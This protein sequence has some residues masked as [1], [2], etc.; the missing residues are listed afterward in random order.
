MT[1]C[2]LLPTRGRVSNL[3][4]FLSSAREMGCSTPGMVILDSDDFADNEFAY[5]QAMA[6]AP[7]GWVVRII[8]NP[9]RCYGGALRTVWDGVKDMDWIGLV[10]DDLVACS[11]NW[12]VSLV[13]ALNRWNFVSSNDGWQSQTGDIARDR[14]HGAIVWAGELARAVGWIF[15][16][17]LNHI[18]HDDVWE[19]IGRET[20]CWQVRKDI[21]VK[22]LHEAL[23]GKVG[24]TMDQSSDLWKHDQAWYQNW[25]KTEK[26][27]VVSRVRAL[28][29]QCG[30]RTMRAD[31]TGVKLMIGTP[32]IDGKYESAYMTSLFQT[33]Q[34]L[35]DNGVTVMVAEEKFTADISLARSKIFG[36]FLRSDC[37]HLLT[38]DSD[39]GWQPEAISR[40]F[41]ANKDFAAAAG[42]KKRYPLQF[43]ASYTDAQGNPIMLQLDAETGTM[44]VGEI[45]SAFAMI[46]H[47]VADKMVQSYPEL[48]YIGVSGETEFA[49]YNPMV[50]NA[51]YRSED[52]AFCTRWRNIGGH[53]YM[54]P[55]IRLQHIGSHTFEGS[56]AEVAYNP[57]QQ[58]AE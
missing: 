24:P 28:Q 53:V 42:P 34:M 49:I 14:M 44:E 8:E 51:R 39:M 37:T 18:F 31:F 56:F 22:H 15:P 5:K 27:E 19:I 13:R 9:D 41:V 11:S 55:E 26:D 12:D 30:I 3:R 20:G 54:I 21:L 25:L 29:G 40:L 10:S 7:P 38:I 58:A 46:T 2:W 33:L 50:T 43:A 17:G 6:L 47:A 16:D 4:R 57:V 1:G 23:D 32:C 35:R 52:F 48:A 36:A 45:G